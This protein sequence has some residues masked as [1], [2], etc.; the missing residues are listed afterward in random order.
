MLMRWRDSG[1]ARLPSRSNTV[2]RLPEWNECDK[3]ELVG[4]PA[5]QHG[6]TEMN[7][8]EQRR[9]AKLI[10]VLTFQEHTISP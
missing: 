2:P 5:T 4:R 1:V 7:K 8:E 9:D 6:S 10:M 3:P